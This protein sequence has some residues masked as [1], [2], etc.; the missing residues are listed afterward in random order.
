MGE[1]KKGLCDILS[2][3]QECLCH[4]EYAVL[5]LKQC[6][7]SYVPKIPLDSDIQKRL[8]SFNITKSICGEI[9]DAKMVAKKS[10]FPSDI[11]WKYAR[12]GQ[13]WK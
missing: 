4:L 2:A 1:R 8:S 12:P 13:Y 9:W 11:P 3:Y 7:W 6:H 10:E 5:N